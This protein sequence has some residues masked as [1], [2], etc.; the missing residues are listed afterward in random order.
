MSRSRPSSC[1]PG[2][3]DHAFFSGKVISARSADEIADIHHLKTIR[4]AVDRSEGVALHYFVGD[5]GAKPRSKA[6]RHR[7]RFLLFGRR[8]TE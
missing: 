2:A 1:G 7:L 8:R 6:P 4:F 5:D 3:A